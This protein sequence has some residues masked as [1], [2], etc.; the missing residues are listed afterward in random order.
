MTKSTIKGNRLLDFAGRK[1]AR[2][3]EPHL[4]SHTLSQREIIYGPN[5]AIE[6]VHFVT[7]GVVSL[8]KK[9]ETGETI[10]IGTVGPEGIVGASLALGSDRADH[11]AIVQV[12]GDSASRWPRRCCKRLDSFS[13]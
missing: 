4:A 12:P 3:L 9:L 5:K 1:E 7:N 10:E 8:V 6:T 11:T 13:T 2:V